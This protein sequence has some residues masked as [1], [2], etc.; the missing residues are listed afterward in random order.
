MLYFLIHIQFQLIN[1]IFIYQLNCLKIIFIFRCQLLIIFL[2]AFQNS[3]F[4]VHDKQFRFR[5]L[6]KLLPSSAVHFNQALCS[7]QI[8]LYTVK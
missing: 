6:I 5:C 3:Q 7:V 8:Y 4:L 1:F 2:Y